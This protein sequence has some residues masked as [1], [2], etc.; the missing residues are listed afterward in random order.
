MP[1]GTLLTNQLDHHPAG[2][3][4]GELSDVCAFAVLWQIR[5]QTVI[6]MRETLDLRLPHRAAEPESMQ[7]DQTGRID[8][9][10]FAQIE[11]H[12]ASS[13]CLDKLA[14]SKP[15]SVPDKLYR[16][17]IIFLQHQPG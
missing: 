10:C 15:D 1:M 9:S 5:C 14:R 7:E 8:G 11:C 2:V 12:R 13:L 3:L 16:C 6:V 17:C 4:Q